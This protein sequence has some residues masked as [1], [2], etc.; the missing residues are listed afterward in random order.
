MSEQA[1]EVVGGHAR[2]GQTRE[3]RLNG[4]DP[5]NLSGCRGCGI[6]SR[7]SN[8]LG[9]VRAAA[10]AVAAALEAWSCA[11]QGPPP[12]DSSSPVQTPS[13]R[14]LEET[15]LIARRL[16]ATATGQPP[17]SFET[18]VAEAVTWADGAMGC[19]QPGRLYTQALLPGYRVQLRAADNK[20]LT[21]HAS[22]RGSLILCPEGLAQP[23]A[24]AGDSR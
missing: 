22:R 5:P 1:L 15:V 11:A 3:S 18:V 19:P 24:P 4:E 8:T 7:M 20:V 23:P 6:I 10:L 9:Q 13:P 16:A 21:F 14:S 2:R 12:H 17:S